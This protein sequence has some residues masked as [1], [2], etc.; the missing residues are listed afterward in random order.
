MYNVTDVGVQSIKLNR[1][2]AVE[3]G[4]YQDLYQ[5]PYSY[6]VTQNTVDSIANKV[7]EAGS[8]EIGA[9]LMAGNAFQ[10]L[11]PTPTPTGQISIA[12]GWAQSRV[13]FVL[14]VEVSLSIGSTQIY[15]F[16]GYTDYNG[17]TPTAIDP[18]MEFTI[19]SYVAVARA[20]AM[21]VNG[22][23][24]VHDIHLASGQIVHNNMLPGLSM[25]PNAQR[26]MRPADIAKGMQ[27]SY[28]ANGVG[29]NAT[30]ETRNVVS[31]DPRL[32]RRSNAIPTNYLAKLA[33]EYVNANR[34]AG[35]GMS[36]SSVL[37]TMIST[38]IDSFPDDIPFLRKLAQIRGMAGATPK[39]FLK[40]L[41]AMDAT[42]PSRI[43][44]AINKGA[45]AAP[46]SR[47]NSQHWAGQDY[48]TIAGFMMTNAVPGLMTDLLLTKISFIATNKTGV[49]IFT[50]IDVKSMTTLDVSPQIPIFSSRFTNEILNDLTY[51]G[52]ILYEIHGTFDLFGDT[53]ISIGLNGNPLTPY[54]HPTFCDQLVTPVIAP[55]RQFYDGAVHNADSL[56]SAINDAARYAS[57]QVG[58]N[59]S[60]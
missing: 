46:V 33:T 50:P 11:A 38:S 56:L 52:Q 44:I 5:R 1:L 45:K 13:R 24:Y 4:T 29:A 58:F 7:A 22:I 17:I 60:L 55:N 28:I 3:T 37:S 12:N 53:V 49:P 25:D 23:P 34:I 47:D 30:Y 26:L 15:Y 48:E 32:S 20:T 42:L 54:I 36:G 19:N 41:I 9:A 43:S 57:S 40:D 16:Q 35:L 39:F 31:S 18:N 59:N 14:E 51:G 6:A 21:G 10:I 2:I 27:S 8:A